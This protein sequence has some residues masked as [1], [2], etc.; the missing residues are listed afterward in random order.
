METLIYMLIEWRR[1]LG[2]SDQL[3]S[4]AYANKNQII[5]IDTKDD[6]TKA[7][8]FRHSNEPYTESVTIKKLLAKI[9]YGRFAK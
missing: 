2:S 3:I 7:C 5:D 1:A 4:Y 9:N 8:T 6:W